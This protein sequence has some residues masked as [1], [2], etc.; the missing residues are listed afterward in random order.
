[1][2]EIAK[3]RYTHDA[4][5]DE[6]LINPAIS[7]GEIAKQFGFTQ[8]WVSIVINS[9]SF[10]ERLAER[11]GQLIDPAIQATINQRLD[12]IAKRSLDKIIERLD[13][14]TSGSIKNA[15]LISMAKLGVGDK[16]T[17]PAGPQIQQ[18]N[19]YVVSLPPP[20]AN[21]AAWLANANPRGLSPVIENQTGG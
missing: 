4:I 20:A 19:L 2:T 1:M 14:P 11:K 5:I 7:Q 3:V 16:N 21:S 13:S 9:D 18:N 10:Q 6:I 8:T 15:D 17:R 12:A